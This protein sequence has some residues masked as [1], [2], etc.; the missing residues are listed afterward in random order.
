MLRVKAGPTN[1]LN[2]GN[3]LIGLGVNEQGSEALKVRELHITGVV[4]CES[5]PIVLNVLMTYF[6]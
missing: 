6:L 4:V 5:I 3:C 2:D 1:H